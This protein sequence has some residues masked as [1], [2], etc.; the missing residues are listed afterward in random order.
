LPREHLAGAR[1]CGKCGCRKFVTRFVCDRCGK[2][3]L[4]HYAR[5]AKEGKEGKEGAT[6]IG[7]IKKGKK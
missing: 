1:K 4:G 3:Y 2:G 7:K 5:E 6:G